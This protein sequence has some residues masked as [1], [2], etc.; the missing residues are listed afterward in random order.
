MSDT[1]KSTL[2][3]RSRAPID[4]AGVQWWE[5]YG[6]AEDKSKSSEFYVQNEVASDEVK[7]ADKS[8]STN[9]SD[10]KFVTFTVSN[11]TNST[12]TPKD[13]VLK[14]WR[15][16]QAKA[17]YEQARKAVINSLK[18]K[19][20]VDL[21][22]AN[23]RSISDTNKT[24]IRK[25]IPSIIITGDNVEE[26]SNLNNGEQGKMD[27]AVGGF[28][29]GFCVGGALGACHARRLQMGPGGE[30][31][32]W[33]PAPRGSRA[34]AAGGLRGLAREDMPVCTIFAKFHMHLTRDVCL[35][36]KNKWACYLK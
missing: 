16:D 17:K 9:V 18:E 8:T 31:A 30:L 12:L 29:G 3:A 36:T 11:N 19:F 5:Q 28:K 26:A 10:E 34:G 23:T 1:V 33:K 4:E 13:K 24:D 2:S 27:R 7:I 25:I 21:K 6:N 20:G 14:K 15:E 22:H 35:K 32:Q